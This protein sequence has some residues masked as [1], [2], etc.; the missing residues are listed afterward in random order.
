[1]I[2][3]L[4]N[5]AEKIIS[6]SIEQVM[7]AKTVEK[8]LQGFAM[9]EGKTVLVSV[10]KA[11]WKMAERAVQL[12]NVDEG[13]V[14]TKYG[15][16]YGEIEKVKCYQAAH[17][18][19]DEN[20]IAATRRAVEMVSNLT[21]KDIVLFLLS[22]GASAL[23]EKPLISLEE[24]QKINDQLLK[25]GASINEINAIRKRLSQVKG[26][27]FAQICAPARVYSIILSDVIGNRA[28]VIGS[29]P[30]CPDGSTVKEV[31]QIVE[32]Y[33]LHFSSR[34]MRLLEEETPKWLDKA[35]TFIGGSVDELCQ[36]AGNI[37]EELGYETRI[38]TT[39]L[40]C[41][42]D[43]AGRELAEIIRK[44][45]KGIKKPLAIIEG[46]E[47]VVHVRGEGLGGRNQELALSACEG[48]SG[49]NACVFSVGSDGTDGP[50]DAAGGYVDGD[51]MDAF[52][53]EETDVN[54]YLAK[55]D[56]YNALKRVD[57]LIVTG[58]T[59][60]NVND[61]TVALIAVKE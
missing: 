56:S 24:L 14:I 55:N 48:I 61:L 45:I 50:T 8:G 53:N 59:G 60:T 16:V 10:G 11:A 43:D 20:G 21:E 3:Q 58:P 12:V 42:A 38:L 9:P 44:E 19:T 22:G 34:V 4:R 6:Y 46:G 1:M 5:D 2:Q 7:P 31:K 37:C 54:E 52:I 15:H 40:D 17:P 27:R 41:E 30:C 29:G 35:E 39:S 47:T 32:K 33:D 13:I 49:L 28:D 51:S 18:V 25:C 26:G 23:F 36:A 57:G